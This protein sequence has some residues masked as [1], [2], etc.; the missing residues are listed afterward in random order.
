MLLDIYQVLENKRRAKI[1]ELQFIGLSI[2]KELMWFQDKD[3]NTGVIPCGLFVWFTAKKMV[4]PDKN[5]EIV[6]TTTSFYL[7][8]K[9]NQWSVS[10]YS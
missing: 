2:D 6:S 3:G 10:S 4:T 9:T 5:G 1:K 8:Q 7:N